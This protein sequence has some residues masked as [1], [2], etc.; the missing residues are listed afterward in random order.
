MILSIFKKGFRWLFLLAR[1]LRDNLLQG[2]F[3]FF[4]LSKVFQQSFSMHFFPNKKKCKRFALTFHF[5]FLLALIFPFG[6][7]SGDRL[8]PRG[9]QSSFVVLTSTTGFPFLTNKQ[10]ELRVSV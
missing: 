10:Y 2:G 5:F 6:Y 1:L 9:D 8:L 4:Y 3:F 7:A